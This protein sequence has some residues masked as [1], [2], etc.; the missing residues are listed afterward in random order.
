[1]SPKEKIIAEFRITDINFRDQYLEEYFHCLLCGSDLEFTQNT[2]HTVLVVEEK[3]QC[4]H[5]KISTHE[6]S[7][8]LQ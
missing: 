1:M 5:C 4:P 6:S 3:A 2:D 8:I 7:H